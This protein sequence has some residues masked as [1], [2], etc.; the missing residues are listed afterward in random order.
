MDVCVYSTHIMIFNLDKC[1]SP[2]LFVYT[3]H[4]FLSSYLDRTLTDTLE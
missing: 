4:A 2:V 1:T 3:R